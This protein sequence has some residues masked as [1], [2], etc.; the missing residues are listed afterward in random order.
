MERLELRQMRYFMVVAGASH[1]GMAAKQ[2]G[3]AQSDLIHQIK[4]IERAIGSALFFRTSDEYSLTLT[5]AGS[6]L[7]G[8]LK[9]LQIAFEDAVQ[10][11]R[12]IGAGKSVRLTL[13]FDGSAMYTHLPLVI[14]RLRTILDGA[15]IELKEVSVHNY[16]PLL[17]EGKLDASFVRDGPETQ[18]LQ[19]TPLA[20]EPFSV[21]VPQSHSLAD[22]TGDLDPAA[23]K[24]EKFIQLSPRNSWLTFERMMSIFRSQDFTPEILIE[25]ADWITAASLVG[26]GVGVSVAPASVSRFSAPGVVYRQLRSEVRSF[27]DLW[28]ISGVRNPAIAR[29][30]KV[31]QEESDSVRKSIAPNH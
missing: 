28:T 1:L 21:L 12:L 22:G 17:L 26:S 19:M 14:E 20:R 2:V 29:L 25:T 15:E 7:L 8:Q 11:T 30:I 4:E 3:L 5:P 6:Y 27:V 23:L 10:A 9:N 16:I 24:L 31:V 13:G 18:G